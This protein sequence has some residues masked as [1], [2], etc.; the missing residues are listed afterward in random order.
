M[1][2][3]PSCFLE[4]RFAASK[5]REPG[6]NLLYGLTGTTSP[7]VFYAKTKKKE[8]AGTAPSGGKRA[9]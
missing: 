5:L 7:P 2:G 6:S 1:V 8:R 3:A 4:L 9:G